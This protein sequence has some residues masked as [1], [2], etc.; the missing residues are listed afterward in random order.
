MSPFNVKL[1]VGVTSRD[2]VILVIT[3]ISLIYVRSLPH[4]V[5]PAAHLESLAWWAMSIVSWPAN[6]STAP[7]IFYLD[8]TSSIISYHSFAALSSLLANSFFW[9][10]IF[11]RCHAHW[12]LDNEKATQVE[13]FLSAGELTERSQQPVS[14][15]LW[16]QWNDM[17]TNREAH[18]WFSIV[19]QGLKS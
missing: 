13:A 1:F 16:K 8:F 6:S 14:D 5:P 19:D 3:T 12:S 18:L 11:V 17:V 4:R 7:F 9:L 10:S 2:T 15:R